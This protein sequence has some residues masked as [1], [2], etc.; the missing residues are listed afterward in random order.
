VIV[1][2]A[3][4]KTAPLAS[5]TVPCN[6]VVAVWAQV[7]VLAQESTPIKASTRRERMEAP[8]VRW[9]KSLLHVVGSQEPKAILAVHSAISSPKFSSPKMQSCKD[10][11]A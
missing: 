5:E 3:S 6:D 1:T 2:V 4:G 11:L 8:L 9:L 7:R 10:F